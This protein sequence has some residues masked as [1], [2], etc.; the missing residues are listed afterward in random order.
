MPNRLM[1]EQKP[2][3]VAFG[4]KCRVIGRFLPSPQPQQ[5]PLEGI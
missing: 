5:P 1:K 3:Q 4:K 2:Y